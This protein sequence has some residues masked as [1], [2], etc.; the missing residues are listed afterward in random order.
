MADDKEI[1]EKIR[2]AARILRE[3]GHSVRLKAIEDKLAKH[4]PDDPPE[5]SEGSE[6]DP[7]P[8]PKKEEPNESGEGREAKKS[9]WW[10]E[11][12]FDT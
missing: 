9:G 7:K 6:G 4:F 8:P 11:G 3:D 12:S 5:G 1:Q 2:E 10:P